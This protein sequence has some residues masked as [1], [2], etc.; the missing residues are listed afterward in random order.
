ML[1]IIVT[2]SPELDLTGIWA[3]LMST[4]SFTY[5]LL[6][7]DKFTP[8]SSKNSP[9]FSFKQGQVTHN[10]GTGP[11]PV[12]WATSCPPFGSG[13]EMVMELQT[14]PP[15][16]LGGGWRLKFFDFGMGW[17]FIKKSTH[18]LRAANSCGILLLPDEVGPGRLG[19]PA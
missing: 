12:L 7:N 11:T 5:F 18:V 16:L 19:P 2:R 3:F 10:V 9:V 6:L 4:F 17:L 1:P 14:H 8:V 15:S 13:I